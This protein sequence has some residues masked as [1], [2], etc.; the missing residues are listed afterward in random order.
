VNNQD[1]F[2]FELKVSCL[3]WVN[4]LGFGTVFSFLLV[5]NFFIQKKT[6]TKLRASVGITKNSSIQNVIVVAIRL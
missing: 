2:F 4:C 6:K 5:Y 3:I 1:K